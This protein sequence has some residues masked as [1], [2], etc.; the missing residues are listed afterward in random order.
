MTTYSSLQ[1]EKLD[2]KG[3][4]QIHVEELDFCKNVLHKLNTDLKIYLIKGAITLNED[5]FY[6]LC[7]A[8]ELLELGRNSGLDLFPLK[9]EQFV[10]Y[11][12]KRT[13]PRIL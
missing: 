5:L 11:E 7:Q 2:D 4:L 10:W 9:L 3:N 1:R 13:N 6:L 8:S 12:S